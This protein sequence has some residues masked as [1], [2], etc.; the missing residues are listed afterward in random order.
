MIITYN[1]SKRKQRL[2]NEMNHINGSPEKMLIFVIRYVMTIKLHF[3]IVMYL[4]AKS[5]ILCYTI[6][7]RY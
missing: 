6:S 4:K 7:A 5:N 1:E 2:I 3:M